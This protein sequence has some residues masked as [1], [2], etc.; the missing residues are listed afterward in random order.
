MYPEANN[1]GYMIKS[2]MQ[3]A[4]PI[5]LNIE[6]PL[7]YNSGPKSYQVIIPI[8]SAITLHI[9]AINKINTPII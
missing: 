3:F 2:H 1:N 7:L 8:F 4:N 9:I 5:I 6:N